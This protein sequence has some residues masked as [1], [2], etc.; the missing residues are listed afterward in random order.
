MAFDDVPMRSKNYI[1]SGHRHLTEERELMIFKFGCLFFPSKKNV[2]TY[3]RSL[4]ARKTGIKFSA[5][6]SYLVLY[7]INC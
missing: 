2:E 3:Q 6:I 1:L 4:E 5:F 7:K